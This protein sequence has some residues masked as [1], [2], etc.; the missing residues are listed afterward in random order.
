MTKWILA[1]GVILSLLAPTA[2][3]ATPPPE[4]WGAADLKVAQHYWGT[5]SP[6]NCASETIYWGV[7]PPAWPERFAAA[8]AALEPGT[9]CEMWIGPM[10]GAYYNC[11]TVVHEYSHWMGFGWGTDPKSITYDEAV[12]WEVFIGACARLVNSR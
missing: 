2:A 10:K 12:G 6:P 7:L 4:G 1:A 5:E 8:T 11:V 9:A 3:E